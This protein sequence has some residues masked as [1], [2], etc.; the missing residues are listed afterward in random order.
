MKLKSPTYLCYCFHAAGNFTR[1]T[2][3]T[4]ML[5]K[6]SSVFLSPSRILN[7]SYLGFHSTPYIQGSPKILQTD[8]RTFL[9]CP[10]LFSLAEQLQNSG[11]ILYFFFQNKGFLLFLFFSSLLWH[12][13]LFGISGITFPL[14][15]SKQI[16][17][18]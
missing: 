1:N 9:V 18:V 13:V 16:T 10:Y 14:Q 8:C 5:A 17:T 15:I 4:E 11:N 7:S 12:F 2:K 3:C 6:I